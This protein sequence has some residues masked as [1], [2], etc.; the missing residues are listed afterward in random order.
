VA[1]PED[2]S[3]WVQV[4]HGPHRLAEMLSL[5]AMADPGLV[6]AARLWLGLTV[7]AELD[8]WFSPLVASATSS[9]IVFSAG[10][11][12][13]LRAGLKGDPEQ[14]RKAWELTAGRHVAL[15]PSVRSEEELTYWSLTD[16][17]KAKTE[18]EKIFNRAL[19][20]VVRN[21]QPQF[22]AWAARALPRLP[23]ELREGKSARY[24]ATAAESQGYKIAEDVRTGLLQPG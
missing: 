12:P 20:S 5:A 16:P 3:Q 21:K 18:A 8:L 22:A 9:G 14:L 7:E 15:S 6:R 10:L 24:L 17:T 11:L 23:S 13:E 1:L 19:V 4:N 2:A